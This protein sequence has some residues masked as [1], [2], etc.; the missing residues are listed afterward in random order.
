VRKKFAKRDSATLG[1]Q[2]FGTRVGRMQLADEFTAAAAGRHY[3]AI[4]VDRDH[5]DYLV[6]TSRDHGSG[7]GMLGAETHGRS[8]I[9]TNTSV[10]VS[11]S[12][13][14]RGTN[15]ARFGKFTQP[16]R[17]ENRPRLRAKLREIVSMRGCS[18]I[19]RQLYPL[20]TPGGRSKIVGPELNLL[21]DQTIGNSM[22]SNRP[23]LNITVCYQNIGDDSI[24]FTYHTYQLEAPQALRRIMT[25]E[26]GKVVATTYLFARLRPVTDKIISQPAAGCMKIVCPHAFPE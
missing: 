17:I 9:D 6:F 22:K 16:T 7:G 19:D 12:G 1:N 24:T 3:P 2:H 15:T 10:N 21:F 13:Q 4:P 14:K 23:R 26:L 11:G 8:R 20:P 25:V 18:L 5:S